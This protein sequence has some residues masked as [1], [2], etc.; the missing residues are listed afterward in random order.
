MS[1]ILF[2]TDLHFGAHEYSETFIEYQFACVRW[3]YEQAEKYNIDKI[4]FLGDVFDKRRSINLKI[5]ENV[6]KNFGN[7]DFE[8]LLLLGNHDVY[9]KNDNAINSLDILFPNSK[10]FTTLPTEI[11]IGNKKFLMVP[12][13]NKENYEKSLKIIKDSTADY[14]CGHL[15]MAGIEL[16]RGFVS[17]IDSVP[18]KILQKF[19]RVFSGHY[20]LFSEKENIM[21]FGSLCQLTWNDYKE[22]KYIGIFD[23][24]KDEL[25][26]VENPLTYFEKIKI[27]DDK[28]IV[29][30]RLNIEQYKDKM[31]KLYLYTERNI[32]VEKIISAIVDIAVKVNIIDEQ[33]LLSTENIKLDTSSME[34]TELWKK[35]LHETE[36]SD[37]EKKYINKIF[38]DTYERV[39]RGDF[40]T[41]F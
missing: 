23:S 39:S 9:Y 22:K 1:R 16:I 2:C 12:W 3:M 36:F 25:E 35:Y 13:I 7:N 5:L 34:L 27:K 32:K 28:D 14:L 31:I 6:Y 18:Q 21:Y 15:D 11:D 30:I 17:E 19:D 10:V 33:V 38:L 20:H 29:Q 8:H 24:E 40:E 41:D 26:L 37:L 4:I